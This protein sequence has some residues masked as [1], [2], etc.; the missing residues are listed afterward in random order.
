MTDRKRRVRKHVIADMS[1]HHVA[2]RIAKC[3]FTFEAT[4]ADYGYDG[5][6]FT[7]DPNGEAENGNVFVQLK[8]T[9]SIR[10]YK[11]TK[12][13]SFRLTKK[14]LDL[15]QAEAFPVYLILFDAMAEI[16][17]WLYLQNY[18]QAHGIS[19]HNLVAQ[20]VAV[21]IDATQIVDVNAIHGWQV[22]KANV[23]AGMGAISHVH[24]T[25][26]DGAPDQGA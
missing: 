25:R 8:A 10:N 9:D 19:S 15:W 5:W 3:G 20:S 2:Y 22:A 18:L 23:L 4:K 11:N 1:L 14:D 17:Y 21:R 6:M 24:E 12:D 16:A 26:Q 13:F 7:F